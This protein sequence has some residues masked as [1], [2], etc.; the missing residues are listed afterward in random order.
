MHR[1]L[2]ATYRYIRV[3]SYKLILSLRFA[4]A[5]GLFLISGRCDNSVILFGEKDGMEARDNAFAL[6][7][8]LYDSGH[9]DVYYIASARCRDQDAIRRFGTNILRYRS[10]RHMVHVFRA[11]LLVVN[12]GYRDVYPNFVGILGKTDAPFLY[13]QHGV[14]RYKR[15]NF[16]AGHYWG[17]ILRFVI[18][19]DFEVDIMTDKTFTVANDRER[20]ELDYVRTLMGKPEP[21]NSRKDLLNF[22]QALRAAAENM[23]NPS[24]A[25]RLVK[26]ARQ[27]E[28]IANRVGM[29]KARLIQSGLPRHDKLASLTPQERNREV[30]I[31][32]TW[33]EKWARKNGPKSP[34]VERIAGILEN[35]QV[36]AVAEQ[37]GLTFK[38]FLH[39]KQ[40][41][42][43]KFLKERLPNNVVFD[44]SGD[45]SKEMGRC[46]ALISDYSSVVFDF[47]LAG[48]P[49]LFY[50][51]DRPDYQSERGDYTES[52]DDWIGPIAR[53][54]SEL[55][56]HLAITFDCDKVYTFRD[57]LLDAYP[58]WG[59]AIP[60]LTK[61]INDIPP[62][63]VFVAYNLFGTGGTVKAVTSF[64][65]YLFERGYQVEVVSLR[66]TKI[67]PDMGLNPAIRVY[68]LQDHTRPQTRMERFLKSFKSILVHKDSDL[69]AQINLLMDLRLI[70]RLRQITAD[71]VIPT[72]PGLVPICTRFTR[73][74]TKVLAME[75]Q[76][77]A[78][79]KPSIQ[80]LI[81][82]HY[83][84]AHGL[85]VLSDRDAEDQ[86]AFSKR[87]YKLPNGVLPPTELLP[88]KA[89]IPRI[90]A[91]GRFERWKRFDLLVDAFATLANEFPEWELH[92]FGEG[93]VHSEIAE[94]IEALGM[95]GRVIL[96]GVTTN[97]IAELAQG[98]ICAVPSEYEP[99]GMVLIE[100]YAA[101]RPVV[102]FDVE[103]GPREIVEHGVTGF[104]AEALNIDDFADRLRSLMR[105]K[106]L[107]EQMGRAAHDAFHA[108]YSMDAAGARLE[109]ILADVVGR[110]V[111]TEDRPANGL[112]SSSP[113]LAQ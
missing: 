78:A 6:F 29:P 19:T 60:T 74:N 106:E 33:R 61:A 13:V 11:R 76:F 22:A 104:R 39:H 3:N 59:H 58:N 5:R 48:S 7:A 101:G 8:S 93:A 65:N 44:E 99:F 57:R 92:M 47:T 18:S 87:I 68:S 105:S 23:E 10:F 98:E 20:I 31:F 1:H 40:R 15:V 100:A 27:A 84:K 90:V 80:K 69:Y 108:K 95:D 35:E 77:Y 110:R 85:T 42:A 26:Q 71:V 94:Q 88:P 41:G 103:T 36:Q 37:Y 72:F 21:I 14:L 79:H 9:R 75:H 83:P 16:T 82:L 81:Q 66:R 55:A 17:R 24:F 102:S 97:S 46:G 112:A 52:D 56:R 70:M 96:R 62:R 34:F 113:A 12:D 4:I 38:V 2:K 67:V 91:L 86:S 28:H 50:H 73:R 43:A 107:R 53:D 51:P 89:D 111:V 25:E 49:V 45:I 32:F 64:A 109:E 54:A 63:V 30:L